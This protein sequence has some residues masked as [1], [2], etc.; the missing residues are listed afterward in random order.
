M[1]SLTVLKYPFVSALFLIL[2][3]HLLVSAAFAQA[4]EAE[5]ASSLANA[6]EGV[7]SAYRSVLKAE[8]VGANVSSLLF[9][10]NEAGGFLSRARMAYRLRDFEETVR[11]AY[12]AE[13]IGLEVESDAVTFKNSA[14]NEGLQHRVLAMITSVLGVTSIALASFWMWHIL[15]KRYKGTDHESELRVGI[16]NEY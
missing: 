8:E 16:M 15:K 4:G 9:R 12:S 11:S 3:S 1:R 10:L 5:A 13:D 7:V 2:V 14:L 6:E